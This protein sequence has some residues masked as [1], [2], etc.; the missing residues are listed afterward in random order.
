MRSD[1]LQAILSEIE[2]ADD[3][4]AGVIE[5]ATIDDLDEEAIEKARK[6]FLKRNPLKKDDLQIWDDSKFLD[7]AKLTI[8]GQ[9]TRAAL[10]LLGKEESE[11]LLSP[12]VAKIRWSLREVGKTLNKDYD[13]FSSS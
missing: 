9:I 3:W 11:H 1:R 6:E 5:E 4:S 8:R 13:I 2:V 7:K 12:Y 10:V